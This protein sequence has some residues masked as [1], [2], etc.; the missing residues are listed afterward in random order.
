MPK[1]YLAIVLHAH[2]P[3]VRHPEFEDFLEEDWLFEAITETYIPFIKVLEGLTRDK[4]N[5]KLTISLSPTL[6]AMLMDQ[7]LQEK[8]LKHLNKLIELSWKEIDRT[9]WEP[10]FNRLAHMYHDS[11]LEARRIFV[12]EYRYNLVNAFKKF[13]ETG[14]LEVITCCATHGFLPLMEVERQAAVRAQVKVATDMYQKVFGRKTLGI[15]LPECGYNPGDDAELKKEGVKYFIV[16]THGVLFGTPRPKYGVF[17][18]VYAPGGVAVFAR[19]SKPLSAVPL[20]LPAPAKC[21][22]LD[23]RPSGVYMLGQRHIQASPEGVLDAG[24]LPPGRSELR[25]AEEKPPAPHSVP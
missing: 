5:Y 18:P 23:A 12:E 11:F 22:L 4:V 14:N 9:K 19:D 3:F 7:N 2:L 8:Y 13:Q 24:E 6:M 21:L 10:Q 17:R 25:L 16:D 15:W 1:G 20:D